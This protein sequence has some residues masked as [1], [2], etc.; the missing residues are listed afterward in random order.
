MPTAQ[1]ALDVFVQEIRRHL[2]GMIVALG[3]AD[4]IVFTGGIGEKGASIRAARLRWSGGTRHRGRSGGQRKRSSGEATFHATDSRTQLWV[5]PTNE[6]VIVARQ[7]VELLQPIV[8]QP[9]R[10]SPPMFIARVTG[11]VVSTQKVAI[12]DRPQAAGRRTVSAGGRKASIAGHDRPDL[13]RRRHARCRRRT[14][15]C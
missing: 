6:E 14:T 12:D 11:S 7:C 9:T 13:H 1:L 2:G 4:A 10:R 5:I 3:G 15:S 8:N